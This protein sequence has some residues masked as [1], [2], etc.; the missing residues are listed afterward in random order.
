MRALYNLNDDPFEMNNL[1][2][3]NPNAYKYEA[4]VAE[5]EYCFIEW[6]MKSRGLDLAA[7]GKSRPGNEEYFSVLPNPANDQVSIRVTNSQLPAIVEILSLEGKVLL[8]ERM[9]SEYTSLVVSHLT[10]GIYSW[11]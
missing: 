11:S 5:L 8:Q 10:P 6:L 2:G 1:L 7:Q 4:K 3:N 9:Q